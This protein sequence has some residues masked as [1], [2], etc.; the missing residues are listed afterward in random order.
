MTNTQPAVATRASRGQKL[1]L[2]AAMLLS[3]ASL[4]W[5]L[6]DFEPE[7]LWPEVMAMNWGW[8]AAAVL[9]DVLVY[10]LQGWRWSLLLRPV[11]FIPYAQSIRAIYVGLFAN[12]VLPL[13][14]GEIIRC[15]LQARW[16]ALP[17]TVILSSAIIERVFD[18]VWL[19]VC[20]LV[21]TRLVD[22][23][24]IYI[25]MGKVLAVVVGALAALI[26]A[27]M[28]FKTQ[29][30]HAF[31]RNRWL[32]KLN[33][34][35]EDLY[36]I[37][38]SPYLY[39]SAGASLPYLLLQVL[40]IYA[41]AQGYGI[42]ITLSQGFVLMVLLRLVSVVPQAPG[43]LGTF[44]AAAVFGLIMFGVDGS[45]ARRFSFVMWAVITLPLLIAGFVALTI[46]G[47]KLSE[48]RKQAEQA[49]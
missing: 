11:A 45:L 19:I 31:Q 10:F 5:V 21:S 30:H 20:L 41:L 40:P 47:L 29:T 42:D 38:H 7:K 14:T 18:G 17:F 32:S 6:H 24:E 49:T 12:E 1:A 48:L 34:L 35:L 43:N 39:L 37:G 15:F 4:A 44:Q 33:V 16:S 46:T 36:L 2:G 26:G 23:P 8:V 28:F 27:A 25:T 3:V 22:V 13:R 9:F